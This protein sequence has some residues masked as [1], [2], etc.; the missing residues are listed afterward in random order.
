MHVGM[1]A[2]TIVSIQ[3]TFTYFCAQFYYVLSLNIYT[4]VCSDTQHSSTD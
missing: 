2:F 4:F 1:S 3:C